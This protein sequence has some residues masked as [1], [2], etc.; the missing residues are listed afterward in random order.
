MTQKPIIVIHLLM[1]FCAVLVAGSF[2]VGEAI[3]GGLDPAIL[4]LVRFAMGTALFAPFIYWRHG[5]DVKVSALIRYSL[6][7]GVLVIFFWAMF[8]ALRTTTALNTSVIFTLVPA[9][10][11]LYARVLV[12]ERLDGRMV[13]LV[14][15]G[16][17]AVWVLF[18]GDP[19]Q[20]LAMNWNQG[21]LIFLGGCL[22]M[23][24]Y[25]PLIRLLHRGESMAV[26]TFWIMVTACGWLL[27]FCGHQLSGVD[28]A[29]I[30]FKIWS[31]IFYLAVFS[32]IISFFIS[33]YAILYLGPTRVMA[34]SYL[35]PPLVLVIN[36]VLGQPWPE[37]IIYPGL[38]L[39]L[40]AMFFFQ[41][42]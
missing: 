2:T 17:G 38:A 40:V 41:R 22:V 31:G 36:R 34:Y 18:R 21:D 24:L 7:S 11:A 6:V 15:S 10:S 12:G 4:T 26:M 5:L 8:Q 33:Q 25:T 1:F 35:Y 30:S 9:I 42:R 20:L 16:V 19:G 39:L 3:A 23:A 27:L 14:L 13:A 37:P 32:T 28:W 29:G